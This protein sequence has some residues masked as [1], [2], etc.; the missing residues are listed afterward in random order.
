MGASGPLES[1]RR[2]FLTPLFLQIL[3]LVALLFAWRGRAFGRLVDP[4]T[5]RRRA[6]VDHVRALGSHYARAG[7]A[8]HVA[9]L[10]A[11]WA[12]ERLRKRVPRGTSGL[13]GLA[14]ELARR[15]GQ[16]ET[17]I[18]RLLLAAHELREGQAPTDYGAGLSGAAHSFM[19]VSAR[20]RAELRTDLSIV[21]DLT[22]L[23]LASQGRSR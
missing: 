4:P 16:D 12:M 14:V 7:A 17:R 8:R 9:R 15:T 2:A 11:A 18:M 22:A 19:G 20:G 3:A 5:N 1:L 13:H 10:Y 23:L 6:F 21:R